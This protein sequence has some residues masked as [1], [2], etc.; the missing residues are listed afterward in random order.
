MKKFKIMSILGLVV[1]VLSIVLLTFNF[2]GTFFNIL[3]CIKIIGFSFF[4]FGLLMRILSR[5]NLFQKYQKAALVI[6]CSS[7]VVSIL[8]G[9]IFIW[10]KSDD[11]II[12]P[13]AF[14]CGS[15]FLIAYIG[16]TEIKNNPSVE[17]KK[18]II[19]ISI[20]STILFCLTFIGGIFS[21]IEYFK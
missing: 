10:L 8:E 14:F 17:R 5:D 21:F 13:G 2:S 12:T 6:M 3:G 15:L 11:S 18:L 19:G 16:F 1:G 9:I 7:L 20:C 4:M